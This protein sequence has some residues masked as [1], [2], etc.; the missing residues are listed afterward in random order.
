MRYD[1]S[2]PLTSRAGPFARRRRS[3]PFN[4]SFPRCR[5]WLSNSNTYPPAPASKFRRVFETSSLFCRD[6]SKVT[7]DVP[8]PPSSERDRETDSLE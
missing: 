3:S 7:T 6:A 2:S 5:P 8:G 4:G 1:I